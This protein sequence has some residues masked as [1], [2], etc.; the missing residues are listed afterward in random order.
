[1]STKSFTICAVAFAMML[2]DCCAEKIVLKRNRRI[3]PD[4]PVQLQQTE[5]CSLDGLMS[6]EMLVFSGTSGTPFFTPQPGDFRLERLGDG[7]VEWVPMTF[8][9]DGWSHPK[10][11][12]Y[13]EHATAQRLELHLRSLYH[14][15]HDQMRAMEMLEFATPRFEIYADAPL[16]PGCRYRLTWRC[17]PNGVRMI[18]SKQIEFAI[19]GAE[20]KQLAAIR[21][22]RP[23]RQY[24]VEVLYPDEESGVTFLSQFTLPRHRHED[25]RISA[26]G[27]SAGR[28][29]D[30]PDPRKRLVKV[31][32]E[33]ER[34]EDGAFA[35][36][37]KPRVA[38]RTSLFGASLDKRGDALI[39]VVDTAAGVPLPQEAGQVTYGFLDRAVFRFEVL[40]E[41]P[42]RLR[43]DEQYWVQR[44]GEINQELIEQA[45]VDERAKRWLAR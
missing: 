44:V 8:G 9:L 25:T 4:E 12:E 21:L 30:P 16:E 28:S 40:T 32:E 33:I 42:L 24:V 27:F 5:S 17:R 29:I 18:E 11:Y 20:D 23:G 19:D 10:E 37:S 2:A 6:G 35:R 38:K 39:R 31:L 22:V 7:P 36:K 41:N 34:L 14:N 3:R 45:R 26:I 1:M 13:P 15:P 43:Q